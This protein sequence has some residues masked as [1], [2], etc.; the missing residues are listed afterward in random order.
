[1]QLIQPNVVG[2]F[3]QSYSMAQDRKREQEEAQYNRQRQMRADERDDRRFAFD[4][5]EAQFRKALQRKDLIARSAFALDTEE[6][7]N[8]SVPQLMQQLGIEGPPPSF[9]DRGRIIAEAQTVGEQL[10][11]QFKERQFKLSERVAN[12]NITQSLAAAAASNR[13][14][15][16][17]ADV[18][19]APRMTEIPANIQANDAK[20]LKEM[21]TEAG[22]AAKIAATLKQAE[23]AINSGYTGPSFGARRAVAGVV[24]EIP[25]LPA[26]A[27]GVAQM[28]PSSLGGDIV[29]GQDRFQDTINVYDQVDQAAK[30]SGIEALKGIGGSDTERELLTAIQT[31]VTPDLRPEENQRRMR[32][33]IRAAEILADKEE[34]AARWLQTYGTLSPQATAPG[35]PTFQSTWRRYQQ[36]EWA[37]HQQNERRIAEEQARSRRTGGNV[38]APTPAQRP[39]ITRVK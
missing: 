31:G 33:Q 38:A 17:A 13:A 10:E 4:M 22:A 24:S 18:P 1:M 29:A 35:A 6:K 14:N 36:Q 21:A 3:L 9:A 26:L 28:L 7:W 12:A 30:I 8:A 19:N 34:M 20:I 27:R 32:A 23:G 5:D 16:S 2:N 39:I 37:K 15:R 25:V 11:Q